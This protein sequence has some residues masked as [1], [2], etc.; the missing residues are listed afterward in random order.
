MYSWHIDSAFMFAA[1]AHEIREIVLKSPHRIYHI[2]HSLGSGWSP[3]GEELLFSR[4]RSR[5]I[6]FLN[7]DE[8]REWQMR[9]ANNPADVIVNRA[10][11]GLARYDLPERRIVPSGGAASEMR[12]EVMKTPAEA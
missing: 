11:W 8:L 5:G 10:D 2:D 4:L 6:P 12:A 1:N 9:A 7:S 3:D